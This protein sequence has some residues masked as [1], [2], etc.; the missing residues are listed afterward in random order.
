[1]YLSLHVWSQAGFNV[2]ALYF[3]FPTGINKGYPNEIF[4]SAKAVEISRNDGKLLP[5]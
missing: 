1:V 5:N 3:T 4:I 2:F